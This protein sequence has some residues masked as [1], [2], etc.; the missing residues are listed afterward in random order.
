MSGSLAVIMSIVGVIIAVVI[1]AMHV[2]AH[3]VIIDSVY[4]AAMQVCG[5][6]ERLY[7]N[8]RSNIDDQKSLDIL[9]LIKQGKEIT[10]SDIKYLQEHQKPIVR[11]LA[12]DIICK[13]V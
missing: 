3:P 5:I 9:N 1:I 8:L 13:L 4:H 11:N 6:D 2:S 12:A 7:E 10:D